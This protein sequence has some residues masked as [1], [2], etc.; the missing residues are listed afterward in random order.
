VL[1]IGVDWLMK[2]GY[3]LTTIAILCCHST[4]VVLAWPLKLVQPSELT[5][6]STPTNIKY[7]PPKVTPAS[8]PTA[9]R[10]LQ[11]GRIKRIDS[12]PNAQAPTPSTADRD[13]QDLRIKRIDS[14][15]NAQAPAPSTADLDLQDGR[16]DRID[17]LAGTQLPVIP[18]PPP[19]P[20]VVN[21][22][23]Q[24]STQIPTQIK[25]QVPTQIKPQT[26]TQ[27]STPPAVTPPPPTPPTFNNS[28]QLST[29]NP[30]QIP[31]QTSTPVTL[32][33]PPIP[34]EKN[35]PLAAPQNMDELL[36]LRMTMDIWTAMYSPLSC[37]DVTPECIQ[38]LQQE[39]VQN[40]PVVRE[41]EEKISTIN[42]KIEQA[43]TNNK[44]SIDLSVFEPAL[45]AFL[46]QDTVVKNGQTQKIGFFDRVGQLFTNPGPV[47]ND[48]LA[49]VGI[50]LLQR[51]YGGGSEAQQAREIQ[52][53]D[54]SAKVAEIDRGKME[55]IVK[56]REKVQQLILDFDLYARE[57]Q[58]EQAI[59]KEEE[60]S[61]KL[62]AVTY[63]LGDGDTNIYL[64]RKVQLEKAKL[65]VYKSW[66]KVRGQIIS[67]KSFVMPR[68]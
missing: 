3:V 32:P 22:L 11:D 45:Q 68:E 20:P 39:A 23:P 27:V 31:T 46:K 48:I 44:K 18:P 51:V 25:Q 47:L 28:T 13:L 8:S 9:D 7:L 57:F 52:L 33:T 29:Q 64:N 55:V 61:F 63:G 24:L 26:S 17:S 14:N 43:K 53:T 38:R 34:T 62:Y 50:P 67:I 58:G 2:G 60:K 10:D 21:V 1:R 65:G 49:G 19:P 30:T 35:N 40:S 56:T 42:T 59:A 15:P 4:E 6:R 41:L 16:I 12:N 5:P 37:L 66:A 36:K 54:L